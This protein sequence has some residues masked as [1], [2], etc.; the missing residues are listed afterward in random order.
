MAKSWVYGAATVVLAHVLWLSLILTQAHVDWVMPVI[1]V[2]LFVM[3][4]IAGIA[5]F[6]TA[7]KAP[8]DPL[9]LALSMAPLTAVLAI[10]GNQLLIL[11]GT[12]LDF[13]GP[14]GNDGLFAVAFGYGIFVAVIGG[15]LGGWVAKRRAAEVPIPAPVD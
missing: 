11:T 8:R 3:I 9:L 1:V 10:A 4:N 7:L 6:I 13:A 15:L 12:R 14:R 2:M 5:A